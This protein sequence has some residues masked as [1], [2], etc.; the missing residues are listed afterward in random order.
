MPAHTESAPDLPRRAELSHLDRLEAEAIYILR[1]T[2]AEADNPVL[3]YSL[4]KESSVMLHLARKAFYPAVPPFPLLHVDT[5]WEFRE[6]YAFR[7]RT[8]AE[9]GMDLL[10][11]VNPEAVE[12]D[13]SPIVHGAARHT[14]ITRTEGLKQALDKWGFDAA[15]GGTPG[16]EGA[17]R[18]KARIF[19]FWSEG[20]RWDPMSQRPELWNLYNCKTRHGETMRV[21]PLSN[22]TELDL[23]L[24]IYREAIPIVPLYLAKGRPVVERDGMLIMVDDD[25]MRLQ[26]GERVQQ[27]KVRFLAPGCYPLSGAIESEAETLPQVILELL[28]AR[29]SGRQGRAMGKAPDG[30]AGNKPHEGHF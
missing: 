18:G 2:A 24:Y 30:S 17:S 8:A 19:S 23:W 21:F 5:R 20:H 3:L 6:M 7:D 14:S 9:A 28:S 27:R 22:W 11:H 10:V 12:N 1:E 15:L 16:D 13:I 29:V 26:P 4:G 25:R